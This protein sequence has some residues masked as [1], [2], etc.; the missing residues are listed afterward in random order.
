MQLALA[1][2]WADAFLTCEEEE[3]ELARMTD[4]SIMINLTDFGTL[5]SWWTPTRARG[6]A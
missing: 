5:A 3:E 4:L 1:H 6:C 2:G